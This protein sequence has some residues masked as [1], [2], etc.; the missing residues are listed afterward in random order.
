MS[1]VS[2]EEAIQIALRHH[3]AGELSQAEAIYWQILAQDPNNPDVLHLLGAIADRA[4][5]H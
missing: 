3:Q 1:N 2:M 5:R 4:G